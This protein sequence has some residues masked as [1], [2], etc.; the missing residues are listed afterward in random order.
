MNT[1]YDYIQRLP[2]KIRKSFLKTNIEQFKAGT[3]KPINYK[4]SSFYSAIDRGLYWAGTPEGHSFW[5]NIANDPV[6]N[7][8]ITYIEEDE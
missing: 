2:I 6:Y 4:V 8:K 7:R 1:I 5:A 3:T